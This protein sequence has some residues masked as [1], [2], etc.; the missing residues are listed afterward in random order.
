M[1]L[2]LNNTPRSLDLWEMTVESRGIEE[3]ITYV[4]REIYT[5]DEEIQKAVADFREAQARIHAR[6]TTLRGY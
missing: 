5:A 4:Y 2:P 1:D 3:A 6:I